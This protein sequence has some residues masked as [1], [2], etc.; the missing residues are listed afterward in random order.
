[1]YYEIV[2]VAKDGKEKILKCLDGFLEAFIEALALRSVTACAVIA[3]NR[4]DDPVFKLEF[5]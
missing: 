1:M 4:D 3:V 2:S 5:Y